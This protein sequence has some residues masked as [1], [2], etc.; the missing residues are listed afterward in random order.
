MS[1]LNFSVSVSDGDLT[2]RLRKSLNDGMRDSADSL[3]DSGEK[4][5]KNAIQKRGRVWRKEL[6]NSFEQDNSK[7]GSGRRAVLRNVAT[8][9]APVEYGAQYGMRGPP[10]AALIPWILDKWNPGSGDADPDGSSK[11]STTRSKQFSTN[12]KL[13]SASSTKNYNRIADESLSS[14]DLTQTTEGRLDA[15][16][17]TS[18][19]N[20]LQSHPE[21]DEA[22]VKRIRD[23]LVSWK[24]NSKPTNESVRRHSALTKLAYNIDGETRGTY[25]GQ[26]SQKDVDAFLSY[27]EASKEY[28]RNAFNDGQDDVTVYRGLT[29]ETGRLARE[30]LDNPSGDSWTLDLNAIDNY[31]TSIRRT[32][33]FDRGIVAEKNVNIDNDVSFVTDHVIWNINQSENEIHLIGGRNVSFNKDT[34]YLVVY[35]GD[36]LQ[37]RN[38]KEYVSLGQVIDSVVSDGWESVEPDNMVAFYRLIREMDKYGISTTTPGGQQ[39]LLDYREAMLGGGSWAKVEDSQNAFMDRM[40]R[41][42]G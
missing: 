7:S 20:A 8:H 1:K 10:I 16:S 14:A 19:L 32:S 9:A 2:K 26:L 3:L 24:G 27:S 33:G 42:I 21:L 18:L 17:S 36:S 6:M 11:N 4:T 23:D 39:R 41:V 22:A 29:R 40:N 5:A 28:F 37:K 13:R 31:T 25:D 38:N 34:L 15:S 35:P 12:R 30:V